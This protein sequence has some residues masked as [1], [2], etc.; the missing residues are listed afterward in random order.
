MATNFVFVPGPGVQ[1]RSGSDHVETPDPDT[2]NEKNSN[3]V[4]CSEGGGSI[5]RQWQLLIILVCICIL[6]RFNPYT[7]LFHA[8][9]DP[10][11]REAAKKF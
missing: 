3:F 11:L 9:M 1:I 2:C 7:E 4:Q 5:H 6:W 8:G 10:F